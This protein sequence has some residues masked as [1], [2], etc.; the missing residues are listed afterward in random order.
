MKRERNQWV[1]PN[2]KLG[3]CIGKNVIVDDVDVVDDDD[4]GGGG[5]GGDDTIVGMDGEYTA[6]NRTHPRWTRHA[7]VLAKCLAS[8]FANQ[9]ARS[10]FW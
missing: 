1:V 10:Q 2:H 4:D 8:R 7:A 6:W 9:I 3:D 5:G